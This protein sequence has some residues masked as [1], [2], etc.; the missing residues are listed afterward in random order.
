VLTAPGGLPY[1]FTPVPGAPMRKARIMNPGFF[2]SS[3][4]RCRYSHSFGQGRVYLILALLKFWKIPSIAGFKGY[5]T[6][7]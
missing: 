2:D 4:N 1:Y 5:D 7:S 3:E 6:K